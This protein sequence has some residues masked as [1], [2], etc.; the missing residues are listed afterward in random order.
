MRLSDL[1][2]DQADEIRLG[3]PANSPYREAAWE[4]LRIFLLPEYG[5]D[6]PILK[7]SFETRMES[8]I[9]KKGYLPDAPSFSAED[10]E[11][12]RELVFSSTK[13]IRDE[14]TLREMISTEASAYLSGQRSP[15]ETAALIQSRASIYIAEQ[16][17]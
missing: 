4:F 12:L 6:I 9:G 3:I 2:G 7:S 5:Y 16:Y 15:D 17:R 13:S 8:N 10:A 1:P 14:G 11:K